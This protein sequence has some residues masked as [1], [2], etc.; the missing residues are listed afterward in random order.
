KAVPGKRIRVHANR[1]LA[2]IDGTIATAWGIAA[3]AGDDPRSAAGTT[4]VLLGDLALLHDA[5]ALLVPPGEPRRRVQLV[6]GNDRGGTIFDDLEVKGTAAPERFDRVLYT[7]H[8][9][10]L[11]ALAAAYGW[12]H[13]TV[14]NRGDLD[15]ALT[16]PPAGPSI[17]EVPLPR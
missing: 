16:S 12:Q 5:G 1:G 14:T 7:P 6:V 2:G 13:S 17:L 4:R 8:D 11:A 3:A 15:R 9:V 10:D